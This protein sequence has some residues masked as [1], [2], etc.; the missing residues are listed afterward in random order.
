[1]IDNQVNATLRKATRGV[2]RLGVVF[3]I[4]RPLCV[5]DQQRELD[6]TPERESKAPRARFDGRA[7]FSL[8]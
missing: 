2:S 8:A 5:P 6:R 1:M 7:I 4:L 3:V